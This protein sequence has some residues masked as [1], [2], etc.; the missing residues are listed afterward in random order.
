MPESVR[1]VENEQRLLYKVRKGLLETLDDSECLGLQNEIEWVDQA[2]QGFIVTPDAMGNLG[3]N[4]GSSTV[5]KSGLAS[6]G[7]PQ[8]SDDIYQYLWLPDDT[9]QGMSLPMQPTCV[10]DPDSVISAQN[11]ILGD[12]SVSTPGADASSQAGHVHREV[13]CHNGADRELNLSRNTEYKCDG[14]KNAEES[15]VPERPLCLP[16]SSKLR[17][18]ATPRRWPAD[19]TVLEVTRGFSRMRQYESL[20]RHNIRPEAF[21]HVFGCRFASRDFKHHRRIWEKAEPSTRAYFAENESAMWKE[22]EQAVENQGIEEQPP[23][24]KPSHSPTHYGPMVMSAA[25][26]YQIP[27]S[28]FIKPNISYYRT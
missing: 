25:S 26:H 2:G 11:A 17:S 27:T 1:F 13:N 6:E 10:L 22:F 21:R 16:H 4:T 8:S 19:F 7:Y 9:E 18:R 23:P 14:R 15:T 24:P 20:F 28:D 12:P 5:D 3:S